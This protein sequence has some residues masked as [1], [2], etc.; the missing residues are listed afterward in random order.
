MFET[1]GF[2]SVCLAVHPNSIDKWKV[3]SPFVGDVLEDD[4][5]YFVFSNGSDNSLADKAHKVVGRIKDIGQFSNEIAFMQKTTAEKSKP[6]VSK[7]IGGMSKL[8]DFS[9]SIFATN[10]NNNTNVMNY[11]NIISLYGRKITLYLTS[12]NKVENILSLVSE[13]KFVGKIYSAERI[14]NTI[15]IKVR[16]LLDTSSPTVKGKKLKDE[17]G[18]EVMDTIPL[19]ATRKYIKLNKFID[20]NERIKLSFSQEDKYISTGLFVKADTHEDEKLFIPIISKYDVKNGEVNFKDDRITQATLAQDLN[21]GKGYPTT[22]ITINAHYEM[23]FILPDN[24]TDFI[25][26]ESFH[27]SVYNLNLDPPFEIYNNRLIFKERLTLYDSL[28]NES[29]SYIFKCGYEFYLGW[30]SKIIA[31]SSSSGNDGI[32]LVRDSMLNHFYKIEHKSNVLW[33]ANPVEKNNDF[34]SAEYDT[35]DERT[36][37]PIDALAKLD[38]NSSKVFQNIEEEGTIITIDNEEMLLLYTQENSGYGSLVAGSAPLTTNIIVM[39]G[40]NGV[41]EE[42]SKDTVLHLR[43]KLSQTINYHLLRPLQD[44][45]TRSPNHKWLMYNMRNFIEKGEE[46]HIKFGTNTGEVDYDYIP[47]IGLDFNIPDL[48]GDLVTCDLNCNARVELPKPRPTGEYLIQANM[49]FTLGAVGEWNNTDHQ[50]ETRRFCSQQAN[51]RI[52]KYGSGE[53]LSILAYQREYYSP[54]EGLYTMDIHGKR[55]MDILKDYYGG[56][57][58]VIG[59]DRAY[60]TPMRFNDNSVLE[61]MMITDIDELKKTSMYITCNDLR[62]DAEHTEFFLSSVSLDLTM[63]TE[64]KKAQIYTQ[65]LPK[66]VFENSLHEVTIGNDCFILE[67]DSDKNSIIFALSDTNYQGFNLWELDKRIIMV[68]YILLQK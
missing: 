62:V 14:D 24:P 6:L 34:L 42:H 57:P 61:D 38:K 25:E 8:K 13:V 43:N 26:G 7:G 46:L 45:T 55:K 33:K 30:A 53:S 59:T 60:V 37:E 21:S 68:I 58:A 19:G 54:S 47:Y 51:G 17:E 15:S 40:Y 56:S 29:Y 4:E 35:I 3:T 63:K 65:V 66:K 20:D 41:F 27:T 28:G 50:R 32:Y 36:T 48:D 12:T 5:E 52:F 44:I 49:A 39:R 31:S 18:K 67:E 22:M 23:S 10:R 1:N 2:M 64:L 16:G 9:F 11:E